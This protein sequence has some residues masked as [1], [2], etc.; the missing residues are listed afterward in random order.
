MSLIWCACSSRVSGSSTTWSWARRPSSAV[1]RTMPGSRGASS[2]RSVS[3]AGCRRAAGGRAEPAAR[4]WNGR[5]SGGPRSRAPAG[6]RRLIESNSEQQAWNRRLTLAGVASGCIVG[7]RERRDQPG[8]LG[9]RRPCPSRVRRPRRPARPGRAGARRR[10]RRGRSPR[11][12]R[13]TGRRAPRRRARCTRVAELLDDRGSCRSPPG[14][15]PGPC[16]RGRPRRPA[17]RARSRR[18]SASCRPIRIRLVAR[19]AGRGRM[20]VIQIDYGARP[21][22]RTGLRACSVALL[23]RDERGR[24]PGRGPRG[25]PGW[26][27]PRRGRRRGRRPCPSAS[28]NQY[29][30]YFDAVLLLGLEVGGVRPGDGLGGE[31]VDV[32]VDVH[33]ER[34]LFL[35]VGGLRGWCLPSLGGAAPRPLGGTTQIGRRSDHDN[36]APSSPVPLDERRWPRSAPGPAGGRRRR[37]PRLPSA[38]SPLRAPDPSGTNVPRRPSVTTV[39]SVSRAR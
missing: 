14:P 10:V 17:A 4:A 15:R 1:S 36:P 24:R 38:A 27:R 13:R 28:S 12:A 30:R 39:P 37:T 25:A 33:E 22:R 21:A 16:P 29:A 5:P 31:P 3:T 9:R 11:R 26:R 35:P 18:A 8:Q 6:G 2:V 20:E 23:D 19:A 7:G 34:H 32:V